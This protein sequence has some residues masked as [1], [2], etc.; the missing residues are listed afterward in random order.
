MNAPATSLNATSALSAA[1]HKAQLWADASL[2]VFAVVMGTRIPDLPGVLAG[3][4]ERREL[5]DYDCLIPGALSRNEAQHAP[6]LVQLV[7]DSPFTDWLLFEAPASLAEW[8]LLAKSAARLTVLR[9]HL[10]NQ[11]EARLPTGETLVLDWMDPEIFAAL[12]AHADVAQLTGFFGPVKQF[13]VAGATGLRHALLEFGGLRQ[14]H[15]P[16]LKAAA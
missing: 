2:E 4:S 15:V 6:Y 8:G 11:R 12:V 1:Q 9:N 10:R 16:I 5:H 14:A 13:S 3:A 7:P